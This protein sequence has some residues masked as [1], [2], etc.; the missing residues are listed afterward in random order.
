[1][2]GNKGAFIYM[3]R[4]SQ[5]VKVALA[6]FVGVFSSGLTQLYTA[7][8]AAADDDTEKKVSICHRT[9]AVTN[10]YVSETIAESAA[11]N[12]YWNEVNGAPITAP[13]D[14]WGDIIPPFVFQQAQ[15]EP[16]NF[17]GLN[18]DA[19]GKAILANGCVVP[20]PS[21]TPTVCTTFPVTH[22]TNLAPN[23][24]TLGAGASFVEGGL[25]LSVPGNWAEST[26]TRSLTGTLKDLGTGITFEPGIAYLGLH[27][28]TSKGVLVYERESS[29]GGNWW[30]TSNFGVA[31]GMGYAAFDSLAHI[32]AA[33]P[34]ATLISLTILYTNPNA[35]ETTV[36][37]VT[38][39]CAQYTFD[40]EEVQPEVIPLPSGIA[41]ICGRANDT[42]PLAGLHYTIKSDT[43]W[44]T[45]HGDAVKTIRTIV[46]QA[47]V[48]YV[49]PDGLTEWSYTYTDWGTPCSVTPEKPVAVDLCYA[50][51]D[52]VRI[53]SMEG[54]AYMV[55][56]VDVSG[57]EITFSGTPIVVTPVA[58]AGYKLPAGTPENWTFNSSSFTNESCIT[59]TKTAGTPTDTNG[60][61]VLS[62]G[63]VVTWTI[64]VTNTSKDATADWFYITVS[65]PNTT[66]QD[67]GLVGRLDAGESKT[68]TATKPLVAADM[69]ACKATNTA[70][71]DVF[72][73]FDEEGVGYNKLES[74]SASATLNFTCP[75]P[76][77]GGHIDGDS[78]TTPAPVVATP[79]VLPATGPVETSKNIFL[80]FI[81]STLAYGATFF[82][83]N[84][85]EIQN[86]SL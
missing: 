21:V 78:T 2:G 14:G 44:V 33:N 79:E 1:M 38:I 56:G 37:S 73:N 75:T 54:I 8:I 84:R 36:T 4:F 85:R 31:S 51:V 68:L 17:P 57:D 5:T 39:G 64:T 3:K 76:G 49:F 15:K 58:K 11:I 66:L 43:G 53:P 61:G 72:Y 67:N 24:W 23:G 34:D 55:N 82:L 18:Y 48:G 29:Y 40:Y 10:M 9:D 27:V 20:A 26:A 25:K 12:R 63:D 7:P 52:F 16:I 74:G 77:Q 22:A 80:V 86:H 41:D 69:L 70:L 81:V 45:D 50:N 28:T 46:Y 35:A 13:D 65:D 19:V 32:V 6:L 42:I 47:E 62:V 60:D 59:V 83:M 71:Y 30:S